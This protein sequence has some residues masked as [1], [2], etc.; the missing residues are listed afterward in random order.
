[1][2]NFPEAT[3]IE[4]P[5]IFLAPVLQPNQLEIFDYWDY[6]RNLEEE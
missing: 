3:I 1:M 2:T 6:N 5:S 4:N